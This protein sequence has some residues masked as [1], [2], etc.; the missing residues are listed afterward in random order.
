MSAPWPAS[1]VR[2][3][4]PADLRQ[5]RSWALDEGVVRDREIGSSRE[6][7]E[8]DTISGTIPRSSGGRNWWAHVKL[9]RLN[10]APTILLDNFEDFLNVAV[11]SRLV[12]EFELRRSPVSLAKSP[13]VAADLAESHE[14]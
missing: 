8:R 11:F 2:R 7:I 5:L 13:D 6:E 3:D 10:T 1:Q 9:T 12:G 14:S 4:W